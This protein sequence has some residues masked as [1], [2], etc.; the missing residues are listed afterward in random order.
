MKNRKR[1]VFGA[2]FLFTRMLLEALLSTAGGVA[3]PGVK[4]VFALKFLL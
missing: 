4:V 3:N 1:A 2:L